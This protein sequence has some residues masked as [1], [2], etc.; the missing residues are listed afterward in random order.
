ML[1]GIL[2]FTADSALGIA[3]KQ[4]SDP[5]PGNLSLYPDVGP[6]LR[7]AVH[8]ALEKR[9]ED[10][11]QTAS[12][13]EA[14][15]ARAAV[16]PLRPAPPPLRVED[17]FPPGSLPEGPAA[18]ARSRPDAPPDRRVETRT[19][20][21][22]HRVPRPEEAGPTASS[23]A[24]RAAPVTQPA[25]PRPPARPTV[26]VVL[27]DGAERIGLTKAFTA[28]G[29]TPVE[30]RSG[31]EALELLMSRTPDAVIVDVVLPK[32]DGFEVARILKGTPTFAKVPVLL[33]GARV[34]RSQE[35]FA[36]QVGADA[37]LARPVPERELV[38]RT[39]RLLTARGFHRTD[40]PSAR[41]GAGPAK[42]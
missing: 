5:V 27:V 14:A 20:V 4:I 30:A 13:F 19:P 25:P 6:E 32:T 18:Y 31:E 35:H 23:L 10:R 11:F 42:T 9:R 16:V 39:W 7:A 34:D 3:M 1:T 2:P 36:K 38:E 22:S 33:L 41:A 37:I 21:A 15:L 40:G 24:A 12:E 28:T 8:R 17:A 29:C 26:F